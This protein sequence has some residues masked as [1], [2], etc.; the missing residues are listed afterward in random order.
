MS[1][2]LG[3]DGLSSSLGGYVSAAQAALPVAAVL[4][5][6]GSA[7][8]GISSAVGTASGAVSLASTASGSQVGTLST[9][10]GL[11][12]HLIG[13]TDA[14]SGIAALQGAGAATASLATTTVAGSYLSRAASNLAGAS[15]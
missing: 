5:G 3:I 11:L 14:L 6:G 4:T 12:G 8:I 15:P 13:G 2:A 9:A 10:A 1:S 7:F